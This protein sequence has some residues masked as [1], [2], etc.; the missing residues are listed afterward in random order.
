MTMSVHKSVT[1][2]RVVRMVKKDEYK[3]ICL[4]CGKTANNVEPD[5]RHYECEKCKKKAVFGAEELLLY[6]A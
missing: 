1:R 3:G 6:M 5:A 2:A 4:A